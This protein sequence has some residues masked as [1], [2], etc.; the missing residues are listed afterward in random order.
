MNKWAMFAAGCVL[1][2]AAIQV[3]A[4][5]EGGDPGRAFFACMAAFYALMWADEFSNR[6][7]S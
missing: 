7:Q 6:G 2:S 3:V 4:L 1:L 5:I